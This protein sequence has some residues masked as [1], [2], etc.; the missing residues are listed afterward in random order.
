MSSLGHL[1][2][3]QEEWGTKAK[4]EGT[5]SG[6]LVAKAAI[7]WIILISVLLYILSRRGE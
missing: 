1:G 3:F 6:G 4:E 2:S 5:S 7:S